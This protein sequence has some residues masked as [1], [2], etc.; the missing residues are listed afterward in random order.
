VTLHLLYNISHHFGYSEPT[1]S[2]K[3]WAK[4]SAFIAGTTTKRSTPLEKNII[5]RDVLD[6]KHIRR[7]LEKRKETLTKGSVSLMSLCQ[8]DL[9][10]NEQLESMSSLLF[11]YTSQADNSTSSKT[12]AGLNSSRT[13]LDILYRQ[14]RILLALFLF[15]LTKQYKRKSN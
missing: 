12:I 11:V 14:A 1:N 10:M 13:I 6:T 4:Q 8:F 7:Q 15:K 9:H 5:Y 2:Q 3:N